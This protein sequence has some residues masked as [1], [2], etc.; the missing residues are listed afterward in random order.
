VGASSFIY[1]TRVAAL[2]M[3]VDNRTIVYMIA[4]V[5][6]SDSV[7][8]AL[9]VQLRLSG[10]VTRG[11]ASGEAFLQTWPS[12]GARCLIL[13]LHM[14][15]LSGVDVQ[16]DLNRMQARIPVIIITA[17]D[18]SDVREEC[19]RLGAFDFLSKPIEMPMLLDAVAG[20]L[21]HDMVESHS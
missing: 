4:V 3:C 16:R 12:S 10:Y 8:K 21:H 20:A 1:F 17:N 18:P 19:L 7:R 14:P 5:D 15:G 13:D 9:I 2:R 11:F 6:D